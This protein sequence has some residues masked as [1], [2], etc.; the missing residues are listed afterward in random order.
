VTG[1]W[2]LRAAVLTFVGGLAVH[3]GCY[4]FA[5][6]E[7]SHE[8]A[9]AHAYLSWLTP[10]AGGLLFLAAVELGAH[11]V[12]PKNTGAPGFPRACTVWRAAT[13]TLLC[14][15]ALQESLETV[16]S[17]E[18]LPLL[19]AIFGAGGWSAVP[20]AVAVGGV[21]ALLLRG[22]ATALRWASRRARRAACRASVAFDPPSAPVLSPHGSVLAGRHAGRAPPALA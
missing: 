18:Q 15:F 9:A 22:A 13:A 5:T 6:P 3:H 21:I 4:I 8:F 19:V 17:H 1:I 10:V 20:L 12:R 7:R 16:L 11:V 2:R 14:A